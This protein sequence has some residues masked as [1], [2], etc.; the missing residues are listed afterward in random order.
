M[1]MTK[2][3]PR[4]K[5]GR[6][7]YEG[8]VLDN[9]MRIAFVGKRSCALDLEIDLSMYPERTNH[10]RYFADVGT[11]EEVIGAFN[12]SCDCTPDCECWK[13]PF[14][15]WGDRFKCDSSVTCVGFKY[16]L[17]EMAVI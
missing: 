13:C 5:L 14:S 1:A 6:I 7:V 16:W 4:D 8:D 10:E 12:E 11:L 3:M 2:A 15:M 9:G 17:D